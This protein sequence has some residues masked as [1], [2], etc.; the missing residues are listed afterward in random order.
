[1]KC[2]EVLMKSFNGD[3]KRYEKANKQKGY[4]KYILL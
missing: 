1:M 3:F 2:K 4:V